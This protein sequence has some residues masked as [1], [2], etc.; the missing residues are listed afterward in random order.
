VPGPATWQPGGGGGGGY[1]GGG[2]GGSGNG[3]AGG[4]GG[5]GSSYAARAKNVVLAPS[6]TGIPLV[7][8]NFK[9]KKCKR[10]KK[11]A[12]GYAKKRGGCKNKRKK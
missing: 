9:P 7:T 5:G 1:F 6:A 12:A 2:A 11:R 4:G 8:I 3:C 10:A